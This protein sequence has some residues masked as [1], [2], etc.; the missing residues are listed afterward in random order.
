[1]F[2]A[3][4]AALG[5][6]GHLM[7][8]G[9]VTILNAKTQNCQIGRKYLTSSRLCIPKN[10]RGGVRRRKTFPLQSFKKIDLK[11]KTSEILPVNSLNLG[12][13]KVVSQQGHDG[14]PVQEFRLI[15]APSRIK[16]PTLITLTSDLFVIIVIT[17][18]KEPRKLAMQQLDQHPRIL[19]KKNTNN[20]SYLQINSVIH[21]IFQRIYANAIDFSHWS[22][23][24]GTQSLTQHSFLLD[25]K[26]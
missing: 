14:S 1:M 19:T 11:E 17:E 6:K 12:C 10:V 26:Q 22:H 13:W 9:L 5:R 25:R 18:N 23:P 20:F 16:D 21:Q 15:K 24:A 4:V 8:F 7:V 3:K 2:L